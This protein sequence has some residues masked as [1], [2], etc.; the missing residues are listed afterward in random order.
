MKLMDFVVW[1]GAR[2]R[3]SELWRRR[4][5]TLGD[6]RR[7]LMLRFYLGLVLVRNTQNGAIGV[8]FLRW[9][10]RVG[11]S[12]DRAIVCNANWKNYL[13]F[14]FAHRHAS[15]KAGFLPPIRSRCPAFQEIHFSRTC[16]KDPGN[17]ET[18]CTCNRADALSLKPQRIKQI[19]R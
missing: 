14:T 8:V 6:E 12:S 3:H 2:R 1:L 18:I 17:C 4:A 16:T 7:D 5:T 13:G 15:A 9:T 11:A 19:E 10:I